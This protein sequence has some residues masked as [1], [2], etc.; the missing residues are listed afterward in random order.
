M[1]FLFLKGVRVS[2]CNCPRKMRQ[3]RDLL[4][5][6]D[7]NETRR[8]KTNGDDIVELRKCANFK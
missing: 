2:T 8:M 3:P 6:R 1:D 7:G 5:A 4:S